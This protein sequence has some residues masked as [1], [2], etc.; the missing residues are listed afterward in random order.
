MCRRVQ[1]NIALA[2][3]IIVFVN[4]DYI[5]ASKLNDIEGIHISNVNLGLIFDCLHP[6][7]HIINLI[8]KP[9]EPLGRKNRI[10][11]IRLMLSGQ[12]SNNSAKC[13][14]TSRHPLPVIFCF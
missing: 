14:L 9:S 12:I 5:F 11:C 7:S 6:N 3:K 13:C 1:K 8:T 4:Q 2:D 10:V